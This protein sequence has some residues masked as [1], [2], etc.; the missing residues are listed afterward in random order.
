MLVR[1]RSAFAYLFTLTGSILPAI[2]PHILFAAVVGI[3]ACL[4]DKYGDHPIDISFSPLGVFGIALSLFLGFRNSASYDRWWEARRQWGMQ[5]ITVRNLGKVIKTVCDDHPEGVSIMRY[6]CA[7][8]HAMRLQYTKNPDAEKDYQSFLSEEEIAFVT[9]YPNVADAVLYL[10]S[11]AARRMHKAQPPVIDSICLIAIQD[12]IS[13]MGNIQGACDRL[14]TTPIPFTYSMMIYR[15]TVLFVMIA[16]FS[17]VQDEGWWTVGIMSVIAYMFFGLDEL[18]HRLENPFDPAY[19]SS[20][21]LTALCRVIDN[22]S[23]VI[24]GVEALPPITPVNEILY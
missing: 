3:V 18:G 22:S 10:A 21:P 15:T 6:A 5:V 17:M 14:I 20:M 11:D 7:H 9:K 12:Q 13:Q 2:V 24:R 16:P 8:S 19:A 4:A 23:A 1:A